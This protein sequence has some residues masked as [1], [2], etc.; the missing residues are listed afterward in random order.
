MTDLYEANETIWHQAHFDSLTELPNRVSLAEGGLGRAIARAQDHDEEVA[1]LYVDLDRLKQVND[2]MGGH[3]GGDLVLAELAA[4]LRDTVEPEDLVARQGGGDEFII[5]LTGPDV[6]QRVDSVAEAVVAV[7]AAP[8]PMGGQEAYMSCSLGAALYPRDA[9]DGEALLQ[10]ADL[11]M[12]SA[13][14]AGGNRARR[15]SAKIGEA[16]QDRLHLM[17]DLDDAWSM[18]SSNCISSRSSNWTAV[19]WPRSRR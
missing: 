17:E 7:V 5:V 11:A 15:Y 3:T 18:T 10:A 4:R 6:G 16:A 14:L 2:R 8:Y 19:P 13:K 9:S 12:Y 1:L